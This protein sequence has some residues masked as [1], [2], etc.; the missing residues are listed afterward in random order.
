MSNSKRKSNRTSTPKLGIGSMLG[1]VAEGAYYILADHV[2]GGRLSSSL[3]SS[4]RY[5]RYGRRGSGG[6]EDDEEGPLNLAAQSQK[7]RQLEGRLGKRLNGPEA[8]AR[9]D[10]PQ[11]QQQ[12]QGLV[13]QSRKRYKDQTPIALVMA[14]ANKRSRTRNAL[15][16]PHEAA[17]ADAKTQEHETINLADGDED[18]SP[19]DKEED[20]GRKPSSEHHR[21]QKEDSG[22]HQYASSYNNDGNNTRQESKKKEYHH[23]RR[24]DRQSGSVGNSCYATGNSLSSD[25]DFRYDDCD[26]FDSYKSGEVDHDDGGGSSIGL[27]MDFDRDPDGN[28]QI[29]KPTAV[30]GPKG[31]GRNK[32]HGA[33]GEAAKGTNTNYGIPS[34]QSI[35]KKKTN[36]GDIFLTVPKLKVPTYTSTVP[37]RAPK[38]TSIGSVDGWSGT[39]TANQGGNDRCATA[40]SS[41]KEESHFSGN[42][43]NKKLK[44]SRDHSDILKS[45]VES[46]ERPDNKR[47]IA[48]VASTPTKNRGNGS[49]ASVS[50]VASASLPKR[51]VGRD[52]PTLNLTKV[53]KGKS[54]KKNAF[55]IKPGCTHAR[56]QR[57]ARRG[58]DSLQSWQNNNAGGESRYGS[59]KG[60]HAGFSPPPMVR[61]FLS[62]PV[63]PPLTT[64]DIDCDFTPSPSRTSRSTRKNK[65]LAGSDAS[66]PLIV[67]SPSD[68]KKRPR[69]RSERTK[70]SPEIVEIG[71]SESEAEDSHDQSTVRT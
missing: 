57:N 26:D 20:I 68:K 22:R 63:Y 66:S 69:R 1:N 12:R 46:A 13:G 38:R 43:P 17:D 41:R 35:P 47:P 32:T 42:A 16:P 40:I 55:P 14:S 8:S 51:D 49:F 5:G 27:D 29:M 70:E 48:S 67:D 11:Q 39:A 18:T 53:D 37:S 44:P 23:G 54:K 59:T 2:S 6:D 56:E 4:G 36:T 31:K 15:Y 3:R 65:T 9:K 60:E 34:G 25:N 24:V 28:D 52:Y 21:H 64:D 30:N 58:G 19:E 45:L 61:L 50:A 62:S 7:D 10:Q 71:S 33:G